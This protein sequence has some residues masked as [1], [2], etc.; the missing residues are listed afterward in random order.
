[1]QDVIFLTL[2]LTFFAAC[3]AYVN[4]I[5]RTTGADAGADVAPPTDSPSATL[6]NDPATEAA[7]SATATFRVLP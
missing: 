6:G 2:I 5:D 3:G 7:T 4:W 1:M